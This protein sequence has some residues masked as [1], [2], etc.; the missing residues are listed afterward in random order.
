MSQYDTSDVFV[1]VENKKKDMKF[2]Q[3][4]KSDY[5]AGIE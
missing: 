5:K 4:P 2:S 1:S 3:R